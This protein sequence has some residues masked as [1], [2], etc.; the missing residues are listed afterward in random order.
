MGH[1]QGRKALPPARREYHC[2]TMLTKP[3]FLALVERELSIL[4]HLAGK[5]RAEHLA[6]RFS[7]GQRSTAELLEYLGTQY[8]GG[9]AHALT[10][11]WDGWEAWEAKRGAVD[12][13]T[14]AAVLDRQLAEVR[15]LLQPIS[16][17]DFLNRASTDARGNPMT[18][19]EA[20]LRTVVAWTYGYKM[21]LFLQAKAAGV[22]GLGSS[23]LW[24]GSDAKP[25]A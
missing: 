22:D 4:K 3:E 10:N 5:L 9:L 11:T 7:P 23:N 17:A 18:L 19:S 13:G 16:D 1:G 2:C 8:V 15:A 21:Q 25:Q 14:F 20:L 6:F 12:L 24:H